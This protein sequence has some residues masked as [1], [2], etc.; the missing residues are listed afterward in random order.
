MNTTLLAALA[1][2]AGAGVFLAADPAD[3]HPDLHLIGWPKSLQV[4]GS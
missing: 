1:L 4:T 2:A 3:A